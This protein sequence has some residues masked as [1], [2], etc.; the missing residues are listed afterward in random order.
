MYLS[1]YET[2]RL[3]AAQLAL[4][5]V[6]DDMAALAARKD[7][8]VRERDAAIQ[9]KFTEFERAVAEA[10]QRHA[11][12]VADAEYDLAALHTKRT[13]LLTEVEHWQ[14]RADA[15]AAEILLCIKREGVHS[16]QKTRGDDS[17]AEA[18]Q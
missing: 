15:D 2:Q 14:L 18:V 8:A 5:R 7:E 3:E 12:A 11:S 4:Q 17:K 10:M 9:K 6:D 1:S 13:R 16:T